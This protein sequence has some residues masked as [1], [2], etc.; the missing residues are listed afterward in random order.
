M[1]VPTSGGRAVAIFSVTVQVEAAVNESVDRLSIS[2]AAVAK[3][4]TGVW[5]YFFGFCLVSWSVRWLVPFTSAST[6]SAFSHPADAGGTFLRKLGTILNCVNSDRE[7][8]T[9]RHNKGLVFI[10]G[11]FVY[12]IF[13]PKSTILRYYRIIKKNT[14][15]YSVFFP[16]RAHDYC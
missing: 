10:I 2:L 15:E 16:P 1:P 5:T 13:R 14:K 6:W 4:A 11:K 7:E 9:V 12:S 8:N 3:P